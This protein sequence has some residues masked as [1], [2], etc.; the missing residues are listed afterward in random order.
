MKAFPLDQGF[1]RLLGLEV[2]ELSDEHARARVSVRDELKQPTGVVHGGVY[3]AIAEGL[4]SLATGSAVA[5]NGGEAAGLAIH[6]S[7]LHSVTDGTIEAVAS[8]RHRGRTTWVW[9]VE[10]SDGRGRLC[11][12]SRTT[13]AIRDANDHRGAPRPNQ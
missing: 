11:A 10:L 13:V 4:T 3:A 7:V 2:L 12:I 6:T 8:R 1:D 5:P 9:Q